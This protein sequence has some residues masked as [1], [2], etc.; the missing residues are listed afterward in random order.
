MA[1]LGVVDFQRWTQFVC[2]EKRP[3]GSPAR[4]STIGVQDVFDPKNH[5]SHAMCKCGCF[6]NGAKPSFSER[7][8]CRGCRRKAA[9]RE[10][11]AGDRPRQ[12]WQTPEV[13]AVTAHNPEVR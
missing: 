13:F 6:A 10:V 9:D 2:P 5:I 8:A 4:R 1:N 11:R 7:L 3:H 12:K